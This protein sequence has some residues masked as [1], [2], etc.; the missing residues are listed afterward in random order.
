MD[1]IYPRVAG[2]D[3]HKKIIVACVLVE[4]EGKVKKEIRS[5]I[6]NTE[7]LQQM[8]EWLKKHQVSHVAMEST[9]VYWKPVF[10]VVENDFMI[11]LGN[12]H[13]IKNVPGRKTDIKDC[14]W[15]ASLMRCGLIRA[16]F[17]PPEAI[18]DL[19]DLTRYRVKLVHTLNSEKNRVQKV[20]EDANVKLSNVLSDMFGKTGRTLLEA[21]L[22]GEEL[23]EE[24]LKG[25]VDR[26]VKAEISEILPA[27]QGHLR[28][29]HCFMIRSHL[30]LISH[31]TK[32]LAELE[33]ELEQCMK[34]YEQQWELLTTI[35]GINKIAAAGV[36]AEIGVN[37]NQ[38][39][40][41]ANLASWAGLCPGNNESA[42]KKKVPESIQEISG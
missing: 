1:V 18:R 3:V 5:F 21:L 37:M 29:H 24:D 31:L 32:C 34:P 7:D 10:H 27:L 23:D 20:L 26:N 8:K 33:K 22:K 38:F 17:I 42:G 15:I 13:H 16:S 9:G 40:N 39:P 35:P 41:A 6:S 12:A 2:L 11:T 14:E 25:M 19:R 36:I 30:E 28:K 4:E